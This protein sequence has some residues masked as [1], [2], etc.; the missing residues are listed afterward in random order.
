MTGVKRTADDVTNA[1]LASMITALTKKVDNSLKQ[2]QKD[3]NFFGDKINKVERRL[4][5]VETEV[6]SKTI[7]ISGLEHKQGEDFNTLCE[8]VIKIAQVLEVNI[9][10]AEIDDIWR[11]GKDKER[12][13]VIFLR[14]IIKREL[15]I[16]VRK[17]KSLTLVDTGGDQEGNIYLNDGHGI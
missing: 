15:I 12:I 2:Q 5:T 8:V 13:K 17:R 3:R 4:N 10:V 6:N 14:W 1:D 7:I 9:T 16:R 11:I